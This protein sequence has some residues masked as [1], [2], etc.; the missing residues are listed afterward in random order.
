M[1]TQV[2]NNVFKDINVEVYRVGPPSLVVLSWDW[3]A[4]TIP[5]NRYTL[6]IYRGESPEE[7]VKIASDLEAATTKRF[8]D[9]SAKLRDKHR[10]YYY[11]IEITDC[12]KGK[13]VKSDVTTWEGKLDLVGIYIVEEHDFLFRYIAGTPILIYKKVTDGKSRCSSC[14]DEVAKRVTKSNCTTCH[15]TGWQGDGVG[16][17]YDPYYVWADLSPDPEMTQIVQWGKIQPT[18][19]DVFM[20]NYPR[21]SVGDMVIEIGTN[22]RWKVANVRDTEKRRTKMLQI[23][24][25]DALERSDVEYK[26]EIPQCYIDKA[27]KELNEIKDE[28]EF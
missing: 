7:M 20:T 8:E 24:R 25:L 18:Q 11:Q 6:D 10:T 3:V 14:W 27:T 5:R 12:K 1:Q 22:K 2:S 13:K 9:Y 21:M 26:I 4:S 17:Y 28:R 19:T 23:V 16:G 15:G